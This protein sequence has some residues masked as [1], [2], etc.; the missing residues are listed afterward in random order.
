MAHF[1]VGLKQIGLIKVCFCI[2]QEHK[3]YQSQ[4]YF[5]KGKKL[6]GIVKR[7]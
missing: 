5:F 3:K 2:K 4:E 6:D 1:L 7:N